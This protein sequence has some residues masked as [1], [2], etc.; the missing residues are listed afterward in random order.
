[1]RDQ[2]PGIKDQ[3]IVQDR[4][5]KPEARSP[6]LAVEIAGIRFANPVLAAP[7]PLGFGREVQSVVDLRAFGGFVTKSVTVEPRAG[8]PYPQ[9]VQTPSGWLNSLGLP[10][11]GLGGFIAKDLPFL[12]T[13]GIPIIVSVAGESVDEFVTL[14]EWVAREADVAAVEVNVA[15]PNV[16]AGL[17][18]GVDA[19][20]TYEL[21]SLLRARCPVPLFVKLTPNVTDIAVV[22]RAAQEA[23]A[24]ALALINTI[25][26]LA[27][28]VERRQPKLGGVTGGLSG[29]AIRPVAVR[30]V[31]EA[32]R[33]C[34]I[35]VIG[36]GGITGADDA[37]E[38]FIAGARAV[39]VGSAVIDTPNVASQLCE[40]L[41]SYLVRHGFSS[42]TD[43][44]GTLEISS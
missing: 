41:T 13:L 2:E 18:F 35:P 19:N 29:P 1:M 42:I 43:V 34:T 24:D 6:S 25:A 8:N 40:G 27:I 38:F 22:A 14:V 17:V 23:G 20:L 39:G 3:T 37:L 33:A 30:M 4:S 26:G 31:W 12:R 10:N 7:G 21:I 28:D 15:C 32:A 36:M 16:H 44:V 11:H 9:V 5:P